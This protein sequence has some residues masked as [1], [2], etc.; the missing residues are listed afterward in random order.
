[1]PFTLCPQLLSKHC[2]GQSWEQGGENPYRPFHFFPIH[3]YFFLWSPSDFDVSP[4]FYYHYYYSWLHSRP[5]QE[6][7]KHYST[8]M[9]KLLAAHLISCAHFSIQMKPGPG[10]QFVNLKSGRSRARIGSSA[11]HPFRKWNEMEWASDPILLQIQSSA[12][13][14][15]WLLQWE[16]ETFNSLW[17]VDSGSFLHSIPFQSR[18]GLLST[19]P[20]DNS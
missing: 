2:W 5:G 15:A 14:T 10:P 7:N 4:L 1:M 17:F 13:T 12:R 16:S 6:M 18:S 3:A 8:Q 9:R 11:G 20:F 19:S